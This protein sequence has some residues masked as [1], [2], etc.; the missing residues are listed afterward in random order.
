MFLRCLLKV[1]PPFFRIKK[2]RGSYVKPWQTHLQ[3]IK[4]LFLWWTQ[5]R[6]KKNFFFFLCWGRACINTPL[7]RLFARRFFSKMIYIFRF[8]CYMKNS[9]KEFFP[10]GFHFWKGIIFELNSF[11]SFLCLIFDYYPQGWGICPIFVLWFWISLW[12]W[13]KAVHWARTIP[14]APRA[15]SFGTKRRRNGKRKWQPHFNRTS[16][17]SAVWWNQ[18]IWRNLTMWFW[19][20]SQKLVEWAV[21][22]T[23]WS[24]RDQVEFQFFESTQFEVYLFTSRRSYCFWFFLYVHHTSLKTNGEC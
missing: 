4:D 14:M 12:I 2:E 3:T 13:F 7:K 24:Q 1:P 16:G 20:F 11:C 10:P 22:S 17:N 6:K 19:F 9:V 23:G 15:S 5:K 21:V 8:K 18:D